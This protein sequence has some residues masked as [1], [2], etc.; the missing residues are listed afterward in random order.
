M[1]R[2]KVLAMILA[3]GEGK[4]LMPLTL[5]RAKPAV[6]FGGHYRLIDFALSNVV[7]SGY[8]RSVVLTQYKSHSLDRHLSTTWR[9]SSLLGN[10][11]ASVPAQ[12]RRGKHWYLGS[13][14][15]VYQ[16]LNIVRD[17]QPD[18]VLIIGA[19]NIY[20]MDFSQM[21][22]DH[23][24]SGLP[25]TIA[26]IRQP[27]ELSSAFGVI[28]KEGSTVKRFL[29]KPKTCEGL[30]DAPTK[31]LVSMGNY[32]FTTK[33]LIAA[34]ETDA[35]NEESAHDMGGNI[36]PY[37]V[38]NGGVNCYDFIDNI[39][40]GCSHTDRDYWRDVGTIDAYYDAHKD[41]I[42]VSPVFNLYN[43]EW[44]TY[45]MPT[46]WL[47]PAK[48]TF[49][50]D[51]RRG[52]AIDS[53]VSPGVIIS[54]GHVLSSILSPQVY[55][56][57]FSLVEGSVV[58]EKANIGRHAVIRNAILDKNVIVE[59]GATVGVDHDL[60]R[61]RGFYVSDGGITVVPKGTIVNKI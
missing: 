47:P 11:V 12:Q 35:Q 31:V 18:Y 28:D 40:P 30:P 45:T 14:D 19:D 41:L 21:V 48:S 23:I 46:G 51:G 43:Y 37:F 42:S 3:G 58:M 4:R 38:N 39:V 26:G 7:N 17:E 16:S 50:D 33:D 15:A 52:M 10:Y 13:A 44:P 29:E 25:C 1:P 57:S 61:K 49:N 9:M 54:G 55:I 34:L 56:H 8:L 53:L 36:V 22:E 20:R 27:I 5:D 6:P 2:T 59:E 60:D 24:K 32:V